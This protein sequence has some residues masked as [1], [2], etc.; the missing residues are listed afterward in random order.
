MEAYNL[1]AFES[2][3]LLIVRFVKPAAPDQALQKISR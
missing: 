3:V 2:L 1:I